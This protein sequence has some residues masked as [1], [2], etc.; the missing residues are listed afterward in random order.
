MYICA[1]Y[2]M[3][4]TEIELKCTG[5]M[6]NAVQMDKSEPKKRNLFSTLIC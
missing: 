3:R 4:V 5:S 2:G 1:I 6:R